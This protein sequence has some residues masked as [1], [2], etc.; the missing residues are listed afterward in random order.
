MYITTKV[1]LNGLAS[2]HEV[3]SVCSGSIILDIAT[4]QNLASRKHGFVFD[5]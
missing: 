2:Y 1:V 3:Y 5:P 4:R